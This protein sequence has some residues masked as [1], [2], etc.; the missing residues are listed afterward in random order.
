GDLTALVRP[1]GD[2]RCRVLMGQGP[3]PDA[4]TIGHYR[5][6]GLDLVPGAGALAAAVPG[7][8]D[9]WLLLLAEYGTLELADVWTYAIDYAENGHPV[10]DGVCKTIAR[11]KD[12]F[13]QHW[14][15]SADQ[16][17]P[18]GQVP[19]PGDMVTN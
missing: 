17:M 18:G 9:A 5:A 15:T 6:E 11:V 14:T 13:T 4:A 19:E 8:F 12:L 2:D 10:L 16:W 3:A 7:S 1:A